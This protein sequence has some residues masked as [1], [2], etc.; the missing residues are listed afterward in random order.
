MVKNEICNVVVQII[1]FTKSE[2][3]HKNFFWFL[4]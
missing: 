1:L 2:K 3:N 4:K